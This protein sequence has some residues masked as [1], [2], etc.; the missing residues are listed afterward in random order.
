MSFEEL[1][2]DKK[3]LLSDG[4]MGT[5]LAKRGLEP[6]ACPELMNVDNPGAISS[7]NESYIQAGS[8]I[9]LTNTFGGSSIKLSMYGLGER[10]CELNSEGVRIA[11]KAASGNALVFGS[12][13]PTGEFLEPLGTLTEKEL[14][15]VFADQVRAMRDSGA[16]GIV[17]ETMSDLDE[18]L[19]GIKAVRDNSDLPVTGSMTFSKGLNGYATMM[20]VRPENAAETLEKAGANCVGANCGSG[21][22]EMIEIA[23]LIKPNTGLPLWFKPNAGLP[24]LIGGK[25]VFRQTPEDMAS[26][27]GDL[28]LNTRNIVVGGCCGTTPE[29]INAMRNQ[30]DLLLKNG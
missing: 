13:G 6:G 8:D 4:A 28:V 25:T 2:N 21:I 24:E 29:H 9:I 30:I 7:V 11:C 18:L 12:I 23:G 16:D 22:D 3:V 5:E 17:F 26:K 20:G 15:K 27:L 14:V 1:L 19:C 10:A